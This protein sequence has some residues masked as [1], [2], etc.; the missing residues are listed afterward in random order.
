MANDLKYLSIYSV[1]RIRQ[2]QF[3]HSILKFCKDSNPVFDVSKPWQG[4]ADF[5][6]RKRYLHHTVRFSNWH[7]NLDTQTSGDLDI[8][9]KIRE[10]TSSCLSWSRFMKVGENLEKLQRFLLSL[11]LIRS[12]IVPWNWCFEAFWPWAYPHFWYPRYHGPRVK[13][14]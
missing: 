11:S 3:T 9:N 1:E 5:A 7:P 8:F 14:G 4:S 2:Q 10:I 6:S 12:F 13:I